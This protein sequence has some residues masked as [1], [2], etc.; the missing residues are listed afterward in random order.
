TSGAEAG[1][2]QSQTQ[3]RSHSRK[4]KVHRLRSASPH[5]AREDGWGVCQLGMTA[6]ECEN[7]GGL[8][9]ERKEPATALSGV[10]QNRRL[11]ENRRRG[12]RCHRSFPS[13]VPCWGWRR[14]R[15]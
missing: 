12:S 6:E 4:H 10:R 3:L 5:C 9:G 14:G 11:R 2:I 1:P 13:N 7:L 15:L 8:P